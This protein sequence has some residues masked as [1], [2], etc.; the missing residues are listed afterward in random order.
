MAAFL[1]KFVKG[2]A[3]FIGAIIGELIVVW[4]YFLTRSGVIELGYLWLNLIGAVLVIGIASLIQ[5]ILNLREGD[6]TE[7]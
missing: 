7:V 2:N 4:I 6:R 1:L 3:V 5:F